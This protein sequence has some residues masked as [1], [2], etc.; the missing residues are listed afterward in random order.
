MVTL[1]VGGQKVGTLAD[2]GKVIAEFIARN[3]PVE[4]RDDAGE[5]VGTFI[6]KPP[7]APPEPLIPWE[8]DVTRDE[9]ERRVRAG[10]RPVAQFSGTPLPPGRRIEEMGAVQ[11]TRREIP[12]GVV[13]VWRRVTR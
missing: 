4:F 11:G 13:G 2:A 9:I 12:P 7:P 6:P 3:H 5:V 10:A 1:Y 8:P